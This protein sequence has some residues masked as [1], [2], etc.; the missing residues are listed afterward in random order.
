MKVKSLLKRKIFVVFV[1]LFAA[2]VFTFLTQ[3][4]I[5][6]G[7]AKIDAKKLGRNS[8]SKPA[9][10]YAK[11]EVL[12]MFKKG[13]KSNTAQAIASAI[14]AKVERTYQAISRINGQL[15]A[16]LISKVNTTME[17]VREL[18]KHPDVTAVS[19]NYRLRI[20]AVTPND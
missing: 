2:F 19:P 17:M 6:D 16:H 5:P 12:V 10:E 20:D 8:G 14:S 13:V 15:H 1:S 18:E 9:P 11:G 4:V 3:A 7:S